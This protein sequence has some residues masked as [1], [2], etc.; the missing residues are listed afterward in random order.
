MASGVQQFVVF[1]GKTE[2]V[3]LT[4]EGAIQILESDVIMLIDEGAN[5]SEIVKGRDLLE[6]IAAGKEARHVRM[7]KVAVNSES[8]DVEMMIAAIQSV[9]AKNPTGRPPYC[10]PE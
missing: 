4:R 9:E 3:R 8:D 10:L 5:Y 7:M 2:K 1:D 6:A